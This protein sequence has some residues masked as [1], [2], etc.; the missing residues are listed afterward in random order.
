MK[1]EH[2]M[3]LTMDEWNRWHDRDVLQ[4]PAT[5]VAVA[6][7]TLVMAPDEVERYLEIRDIKRQNP[8]QYEN[9]S[10]SPR[11]SLA[12]YRVMTNGARHRQNSIIKN[13]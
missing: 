8:V 13:Y 9:N 1:R 6:G 2:G 3:A 12:I 4:Y 5:H 10:S 7:T 11:P